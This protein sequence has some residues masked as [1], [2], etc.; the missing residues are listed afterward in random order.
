MYLV[1]GCDDDEEDKDDTRCK[2]EPMTK[3]NSGNNRKECIDSCFIIIKWQK[4]LQDIL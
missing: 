3:K 4:W 1:W 2:K